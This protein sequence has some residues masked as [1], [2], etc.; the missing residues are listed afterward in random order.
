MIPICEPLFG[1]EELSNVIECIKSGW[2]SSQGTFV[3]QFEQEFARYIGIKY[4]I[5]TSSGTAA[6]HLALV[7]LGIGKGDEVIVPTLTFIATANAVTYT[8]AK[9][10]FVDSN[11]DYWCI[12]PE[13]IEEAITKKTKAIIPVHLYGHPADMEA[14]IRLALKHRLHIIEDAAEAHGAKYRG[15]MVS[16]LGTIGCFSFYANKIITTG[17]GG[18]CLTNNEELANKMKVLRDHGM[19]PKKRY[20][21][22]L[23]GFNYRMTN[24]Q[25]AIGLAQ[26]HNIRRIITMRLKV[27]D[28]YKH[29][30]EGLDITLPPQKEWAETANWIFTIL[31][32]NKDRIVKELNKAGI[33]T[34]PMFYPIHTIPPYARPE[35]YPVAE[36]LSR[37]GFSLPSSPA[38]SYTNIHYICEVIRENSLS[39]S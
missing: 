20:W 8:G 28:H 14:I 12:E 17:E 24:L 30:L 23:I 34:R 33:D 35:K 15:K 7:S 32:N 31:S 2:I 27:T 25:A 9:P 22:D 13:R 1:L 5:A 18:M 37:R 38:L 3:K 29:L 21:H 19:N 39:T 10:I 26:L 4:G 36:S 16:S 11:P 6:L